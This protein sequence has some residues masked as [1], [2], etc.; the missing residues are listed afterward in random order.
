MARRDRYCARGAP[1]Y[2]N[3]DDII[4]YAR[5]KMLCRFLRTKSR[6]THLGI[7]DPLEEG[8]E[9]SEKRS[10]AMVYNEHRDRADRDTTS[11]LR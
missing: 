2:T 11:R 4:I 5:K 8:A 6:N 7:A 1:D 3:N 10:R 9:A